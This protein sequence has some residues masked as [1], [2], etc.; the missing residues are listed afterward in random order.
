[1]RSG[2]ASGESTGLEGWE[3]GQGLGGRPRAAETAG[4]PRQEEG[5]LAARARLGQEGPGESSIC[6]T[7]ER[8]CVRRLVLLDSELGGDFSAFKPTFQRVA[9][10]GLR[11]AGLNRAPVGLGGAEAGRPTLVQVC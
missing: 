1:M 11:E 3:T 8:D 7:H 9:L 10:E 4:I 6:Q 5:S 2:R